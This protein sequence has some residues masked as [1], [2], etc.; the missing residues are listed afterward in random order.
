[1]KKIII[2]T[3]D[4]IKNPNYGGGGAVSIHEVAKRLAKK[5]DIC[6]LSANYPGARDEICENVNYKRIGFSFAGPI[7]GQLLFHLFVIFEA[8]KGNYDLWI[9]SFTPPFS[10][11]FVPIFTK[12][13]VIGLVHMLSG[14]DMHRKYGIPFEIVER[15]GLS[16]Y[17]S[18]IVVN[19][20]CRHKI[21]KANPKAEIF[22][23]PN[24]VNVRNPTAE[25][26]KKKCILFLGRIE[27]N[28]KGID[29][30]LNAY[31]EISRKQNVDL[32][33]AGS[34]REM[35]LRKLK[36]E[37]D[38]LK[39]KGIRFLGRVEG[40]EKEKLFQSALFLV[41][42]S[43]FETF[44]LVALEALSHS[45]PIVCFDIPAFNWIP[46]SCAM[47]AKA[48]DVGEFS[49]KCLLLIKE[50][51]LRQKMGLAGRKFALKFSWDRVAKR[52]EW[53]FNKVLGVDRRKDLKEVIK[54]F[55][56]G[57]SFV[58]ISPHMDDCIFSAGATISHL[59]KV[60]KVVVINVFTK[61]D[62]KTF[63]LPLLGFLLG[64][65]SLRV[66]DIF[67]KRRNEDRK[68][69]SKL[70]IK[71][72]NLNF[73]DAIFRKKESVKGNGTFLKILK[74]NI[75]PSGKNLFAG[76]V[77][78]EDEKIKTK[79]YAK[80]EK[81]LSKLG[82]DYIIFCPYGVGGHVDHI[83]V[84]EIC[85]ENFAKVI[86]WKDQP[87]ASIQK[88]TERLFNL[89]FK[90]DSTKRELV[91]GYKQETRHFEKTNFWE[92]DEEFLIKKW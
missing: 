44:S 51:N 91:F 30:L 24:G 45:I 17:S 41:I 32:V 15:F 67:R 80:I 38:K 92:E 85:E 39:L 84:R 69:F 34:G 78:E 46:N 42:P 33:I 22:V 14:E 63:S 89:Y 90:P 55:P 36:K 23:I 5:Y 11:S 76:K 47:K 72:V 73:V 26:A 52:Y 12:K 25:G 13:P 48:F 75:Y 59:A 37:I 3:F 82:K 68:V 66:E 65:K 1:M 31:K 9:E 43:R 4:S 10:T 86:F 83:L 35:E 2:S 87:Y 7:L 16:F 18:F 56:K 64:Y 49:A 88:K 81:F 61:Y 40:E 57:A 20:F 50:A 70:A 53:V 19:D 62:R 54:S 27:M 60:A 79:I 58:F 21:L 8:I 74:N 6:V 29:L 71:P 28:Q 77:S